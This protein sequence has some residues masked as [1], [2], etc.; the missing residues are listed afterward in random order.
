MQGWSAEQR[1]QRAGGV[2]VHRESRTG[3][4][5]GGWEKSETWWP[6]AGQQQR[7]AEE[8]GERQL[9]GAALSLRRELESWRGLK[10]R[11]QG[12]GHRAQGAGR[13]AGRVSQQL[14]SCS[15]NCRLLVIVSRSL[16][17]C[18]PCP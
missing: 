14:S 5:E 12:T 11:A 4:E 16:S 1:R 18:F 8:R 3:Q 7:G 17:I 9:G 15:M 13:G 2:L 6:K 10:C